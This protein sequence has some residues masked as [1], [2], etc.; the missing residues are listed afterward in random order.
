VEYNNKVHSSTGETPNDRFRNAV[1]KKPLR[2]V[3]DLDHFNS[4]FFFREERVV[5]KS[6]YIRFNANL[7]KTPLVPGEII[8]I[9]FDPFDISQIALFQNDKPLGVFA[10]A[11]LNQKKYA[12]MPESH[13]RSG[14]EV[15]ES[16][17]RYFERIRQKHLEN[18]RK[19]TDAI[20]FSNIIKPKETSD[21]SDH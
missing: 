11:R 9:R 10:A 13:P 16:A 7:Y 4:L 17:K 8:L 19:N 20:S 18:I 14:Q 1:E 15:S 12:N 2:R 21:E 5:D 6:G 3:T